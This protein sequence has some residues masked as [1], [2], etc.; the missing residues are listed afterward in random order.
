MIF[1][2]YLADPGAG[3]E[4]SIFQLRLWPKVSAPCGSGSTT[5]WNSTVILSNVALKI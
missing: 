1:S 2:Y 5:L 4:T 3:A